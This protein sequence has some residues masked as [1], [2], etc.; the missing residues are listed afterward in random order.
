MQA[1]PIAESRARCGSVS[2]KLC[3]TSKVR[4]STSRDGPTAR[5]CRDNRRQQSPAIH[6]ASGRRRAGLTAAGIALLVLASSTSI[7]EAQQGRSSGLHLELHEATSIPLPRGAAVLGGTLGAAGDI[8]IW[9]PS[10][11]W[12]FSTPHSGVQQVC[13]G[14]KLEPRYVV[15]R[16]P[17]IKAEIFDSV[18]SSV[19]VVDTAGHCFR[20][21]ETLFERAESIVAATQVGWAQVETRPG[22]APIVRW[23]G[24][25]GVRTDTIRM[26]DDVRLGDATDLTARGERESLLL[27]EAAFPFRILRYVSGHYLSVVTDPGG[28]FTGAERSA[29]QAWT[30]LPAV[31]LDQ[32]YLQVLADPRSDERRLMLFSDTGRLVQS[33]IVEVAMGVL[34]ADPRTRT[35]LAIRNVGVPELVIYTWRWRAPGR[36]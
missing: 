14:M 11:V 20:R 28:L 31:R 24:R 32:A 10:E 6:A 30:A 21:N 2:A 29:L 3:V 26:R 15:H 27:A 17:P 23:V 1:L 12:E 16:A 25:D 36:S 13:A 35:V 7:A 22:A 18:T 33:T 34:D 19:V 8:L 5:G 4:G 9:T